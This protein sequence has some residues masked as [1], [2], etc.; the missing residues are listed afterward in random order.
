MRLFSSSFCQ[1][2]T[3]IRS[4]QLRQIL[5]NSLEPNSIKWGYNLSKTTKYSPGAYKLEFDNGQEEIVDFVVGADGAW[6]RL[7][8]LL[9]PSKPIYIGI[10]F[11]DLNI[12][13][14]ESYP[15][16]SELVGQGLIFIMSNGKGILAQRNSGGRVRVYVALRVDENWLENESG[17][18]IDNLD[19]ARTSI[20][21]LF[22]GWHSSALDLIRHCDAITPRKIYALPVSHKWETQSGITLLGDAAHL[23]SPFAGEGVNLAMIDAHDLAFALVEAS[24]SGSLADLVKA[25]EEKMLERSKVAAQESV[26]NMEIMFSETTPK[27]FVDLIARHG[28][29]PTQE[30]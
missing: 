10:T 6:S 18:N 3:F 27:P 24:A 28:G 20:A 5:L 8:A 11:L 17:I 30:K 12:S 13:A 21:D 16:L 1:C 19:A 9:S 7:R 23:M 14:I 15:E 22:S 4:I 2:S 26:D 29:P 25:Y